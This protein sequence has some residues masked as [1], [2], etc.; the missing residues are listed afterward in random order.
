MPEDFQKTEPATP[1]RREEVRKRGQVA[2]SIEINSAFV[3]LFLLLFL[4]IFGSKIFEIFNFISV[5]SFTYAPRINLTFDY[6]QT[7]FLFI[8]GI[9]AR[10]ILPIFLISLLVGIL[11]NLFQVG[12]VVS[13]TPLTP[14]FNKINP[15]AGFVRIFSTRGAVE[16]LKSF[17]KIAIVGYIAYTTIK[18]EIH[19]FP[20]MATME[21]K[22]SSL[23]ILK[24][25][26]NL[27]IKITIVL[28]I[29]AILDYLY[30][31]YEFERSIRMSRQEIKE[32][33]KQLEGDPHIRARIRQRQREI[34]RRRMM[35]EVPRA[36]VVITNPVHIAVAIR[37][38]RKEMNAPK[39]IAKGQRLIAERIKE[40]AKQHNIPIIEDPPL[41]QRLYKM[42]NIGQ[43]IPTVLYKAVAEIL[44]FVYSLKR[45]KI[46][47]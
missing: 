16:L 18:S 43:E 15:V 13:G 28:I 36:D 27:A 9:L 2:K 38:D 23:I 31:R 8:M 24:I 14:D 17:I 34:A 22:Q 25:T 4:R 7:Y 39:V 33:Y 45:K 26:Y 6:F 5:Y 30:Q 40:I 19:I 46:A 3:L 35:M 41:A 29:L 47:I 20:L 44:A 12:F 11:V 32:E 42:V 1:R 10:L 37:Y 21:I